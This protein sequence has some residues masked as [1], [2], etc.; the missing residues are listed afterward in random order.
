M[1]KEETLKCPLGKENIL[2]QQLRTP[3]IQSF[4]IEMAELNLYF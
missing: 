3:Q 1:T 4:C 2:Y